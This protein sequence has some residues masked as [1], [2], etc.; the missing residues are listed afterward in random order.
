MTHFK[1]FD[2]RHPTPLGG[3]IDAM[4]LHALFG[5]D[6]KPP[7]PTGARV[8]RAD[9]TTFSNGQKVATIDKAVNGQLWLKETDTHTTAG[10]L[11]AAGEHSFQ[12]GDRVFY[13]SS[14]G[15][16]RK[17]FGTFIQYDK[18]HKGAAWCD[19]DGSG[20]CHMPTDRMFYDAPVKAA[21]AEVKATSAAAKALPINVS[22]PI[23]RTDGA[24]A[25][26]LMIIPPEK[27]VSH[28]RR[29]IARLTNKLGET[30]VDTF[31]MEGKGGGGGLGIMNVPKPVPVPKSYS[32]WV[33]VVEGG[34]GDAGFEI[35]LAHK[36]R[37]MADRVAGSR[38]IA[39]LEIKVT[40]GQGL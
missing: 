38:R 30:Y 25:E 35:G 26:I 2:T 32:G 40:E 17:C 7:F 22:E 16:K 9:G 39:C 24:A 8:E 4:L 37:G 5:C 33:N 19:F 15:D 10:Y 3:A 29:I 12:K 23:Q 36:T 13:V 14:G 21:S 31:T 11:K 1:I 18:P 6:S 27:A 34:A 28:N 20:E